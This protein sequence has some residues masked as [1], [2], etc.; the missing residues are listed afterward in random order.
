MGDPMKLTLSV[1][2]H[3]LCD[4]KPFRC[5]PTLLHCVWIDLGRLEATPAV[6]VSKVQPCT[7]TWAE[8]AVCAMV[9]GRETLDVVK[10]PLFR[11]AKK[12]SEVKELVK[13]EE[14]SEEGA[15]EK[16][17][18]AM[19][20]EAKVDEAKE[21]V[22]K[23]D[24]A[25]EEAKEDNETQASSTE[26]A[27]ED[28]ETKK[29]EDEDDTVPLA[30]K[31]ARSVRLPSWAKTRQVWFFSAEEGKSGATVVISAPLEKTAQEDGADE[32]WDEPVV[33]RIDETED[34][35]G[36]VKHDPEGEEEK[37]KEK[38]KG[39]DAEEESGEQNEEKE[40]LETVKAADTST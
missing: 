6:D 27:K 20:E 9:C 24:D 40:E 26:D 29:E 15:A 2:T 38:E 39:E 14:A 16:E 12:K 8:K 22:A 31:P 18:E 32:S 3:R 34:L 33:F 25:V 17:A 1:F 10:V 5:R 13:E 7:L 11:Q 35:G 36:W 37:E 23:E 21:D 19:E 28:N 30:F 4:T